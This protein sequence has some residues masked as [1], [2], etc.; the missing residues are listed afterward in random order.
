M[1]LRTGGAE[2]LPPEDLPSCLQAVGVELLEQLFDQAQDVAFFVKD[3]RGRYVAVNQSLVERHGLQHKVDVLGKRPSD[4]GPGD[5]GRIPAQQDAD[6]LRTGTALVDHLEL[7]WYRPHE[8]VWCLTTKLPIRD[9]ADAVTGLVGFSKD[10]RVAVEPEEI[11]L[12]FARALEEFE[13]DLS[14]AV[15]PA[16]L[17]QR[18]SLSPQRLARLTKR[19]HGLTPGQFITKTRIAAASRLLRETDRSIAEIAMACGF[20]DHSAF[21]RAFRSATGF[22]PTAFRKQ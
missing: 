21:A 22:T 13:R 16:W 5:F 18:S 3:V 17:A 8:P 11:P 20:Y 10:V 14:E 19:L 9:A 7:Q 2:E 15:T 4:I 6:V 12:E 1:N